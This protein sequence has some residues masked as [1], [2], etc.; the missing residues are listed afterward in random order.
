MSTDNLE[1]GQP[2]AD[3]PA[4]PVEPSPRSQIVLGGNRWPDV[5]G[6]LLVGLVLY[7]GLLWFAFSFEQGGRLDVLLLAGV[8]GTTIGWTVGIF[9]SSPKM[10]ERKEKAPFT[11]LIY[12]FVAGY[13]LSK[14]DPVITRGVETGIQTTVTVFGFTCFLIALALTYVIRR[15]WT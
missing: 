3:S 1:S 14:V 4:Q 6:P 13:V 12:A 8:F 9:S 5:F 7:V 15:H 2:R 10:D 11:N